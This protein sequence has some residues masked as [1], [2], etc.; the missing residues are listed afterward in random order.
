[1]S[2][3]PESPT[4][5]E[6]IY[7]LELDDPVEGG[8]EGIDNL[9]AKQ[10]AN[11]T[12][13]L[14]EQVESIGDGLGEHASSEDPHPQYLTKLE[15]DGLYRS[16]ESAVNKGGDTME[17][18]LTLAGNPTQA[19]HAVPKQYVDAVV[20]Q[21]NAAV[22]R[23]VNST[24]A[25][26]ATGVSTTITLSASAYY[27]L[28]GIAHSAAQFQVS[29]TADFASTVRDTT[30]GAVTSW[31]VSPALST[32][33]AYYW[34]VRYKDAENTWSDW[35]TPTLFTTSAAIITT[36]S[37]TSPAAGATGVSRTPT[38]TSSAFA[39]TDGTDTHASSRWQVATD[40]AFTNLVVDSGNSTTAK[41][42]YT[43]GT[44]LNY[45]T[46][47]YARVMHNG[48]ALGGSSWS[49]TV[50]F[51]VLVGEVVTPSI[52]S[53]T[54]GATNVSMSPSLTSSAFAYAGAADTHAMTDWEIRTAANG[55]GTLTWS[56]TNN[57]TNKVNITASGL[58][59]STTY[60][61]RCR[62]KGTTYGWSAWSADVSFTTQASA[63]QIEYR[64]P[65][66]YSFVV[67]NGVT[68]I[69]AVGV[70]GGASGGG[71]SST[72]GGDG[73]PG[74][75]LVYA[76]NIPVT[77]GE[78]LTVQVGA[79]GIG[80]PANTNTSYDLGNST[81]ITR[82]TTILLRASGGG[83]AENIGTVG[84]TGGLGGSGNSNGG[85]G[86]GGAAGYAG[87]GGAGGNGGFTQGTAGTGG[88]ASG[89]NG[90]TNGAMV[91]TSHRNGGGQGGHVGMQGQGASGTVPMNIVATGG[92]SGSPDT[93][94]VGGLAGRETGGGGGGTSNTRGGGG[95]G[96]NVNFPGGDGG[97]GGVRIIW[98]GTTRQFP[99]TNTGDV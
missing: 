67:P 41:T 70:G 91:S 48:T 69:S 56:S 93:G 30:L 49:N 24:P 27:S 71:G 42:S 4:W 95:G 61:A 40:A 55:G 20:G 65:G 7:Q 38:L 84:G 5:E 79:G 57:S 98:P 89:G 51:T 72:R 60:Y 8:P 59:G 28:Y 97:A 36:P 66:I 99:S 39:V 2:N 29:T 81:T 14:K 85:G 17:G 77:P 13:Y 44:N 1:M 12:A 96:G 73:G 15:A 86:G 33:T 3:L 18:P 64:T 6:G 9:Q 54:S 22:R 23:P 45:G 52:T 83:R 21:G 35:S 74:G 92:K 46:T 26:N 62:H 19:M 58:A 11:R 47:Y 37:I 34:R 63:G 90:G 53:P 88:A 80:R 82:D 94:L 78:T 16:L 31:A 50:S 32:N 68:S 10:L 25:A 43:L 87:N 75:D 76:N